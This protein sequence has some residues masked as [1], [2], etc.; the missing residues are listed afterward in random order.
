MYSVCI[1]S[2]ASCPFLFVLMSAFS[3]CSA[4]K[5]GLLLKLAY[6][7]S[8]TSV[9]TRF[10]FPGFGALILSPDFVLSVRSHPRS[11]VHSQATSA[12]DD[13]GALNGHGIRE[14]TSVINLP[15]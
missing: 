15:E 13:A 8:K 1:Q 5:G 10:S 12:S 6:L 9:Q 2:A 14:A 4:I 11:A 3:G 7:P